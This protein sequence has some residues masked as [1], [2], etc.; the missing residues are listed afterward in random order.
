M[1]PAVNEAHQVLAALLYVALV[2]GG[3]AVLLFIATKL[4]G[5]L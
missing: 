1:T 5:K 3:I 2:N 4:E